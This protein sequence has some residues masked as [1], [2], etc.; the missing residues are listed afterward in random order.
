MEVTG[1]TPA[2]TFRDEGEAAAYA[3]QLV[4]A[5][6]FGYVARGTHPPLMLLESANGLNRLIR[7][8]VGGSGH[9]AS[10]APVPGTSE[11]ANSPDPQLCDQ[12]VLTAKEAARYAEVSAEYATRIFRRG[13]LGPRTRKVNGMWSVDSR[14]LAAWCEARRR[15]ENSQEAA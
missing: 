14:E 5:I 6:R 4:E 11:P 8:S 15:K 1:G 9:T 7:G 3:R 12:P 10:S 2:I 13:D